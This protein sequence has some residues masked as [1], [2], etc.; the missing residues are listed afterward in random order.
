LSGNGLAFANGA[1]EI[2]VGVGYSIE[3]AAA[4]VVTGKALSTR[5]TEYVRKRLQGHPDGAGGAMASRVERVED[6]GAYRGRRQA[7]RRPGRRP[8]SGDARR[9]RQ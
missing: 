1:R 5:D 2:V 3:Q 6:P 9:A 8:G 7:G 4:A